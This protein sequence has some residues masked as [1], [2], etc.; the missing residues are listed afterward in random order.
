M[1]I[2]H[3]SSQPTST[4]IPNHKFITSKGPLLSPT[5]NHGQGL[6][7]RDQVDDVRDA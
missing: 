7:M 5:T 1:A 2:H 6:D 3:P 4:P